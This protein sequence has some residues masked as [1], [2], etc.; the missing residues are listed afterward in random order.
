MPELPEVETVRRGLA[1]HLVG[2]RLQGARVRE[3]RLRWPVPD[4][5]DARLRGQPILDL[6]RRGKYLL[7]QL[8]DGHLIL[9]LGMS[10]SLRLTRSDSPPGPHDHLDLLLTD[11]QAL[12]FRDPRRFG[13]VLWSVAPLQHPLL[14]RLG[15]EPLQDGFSGDWLYAA[16]RQ[17]RVPIKTLLMDAHLI[18]GVGNI[19]ANEALFRAGIHP[20]CPAGRLGRARCGRLAEA[21]KTTLAA[22]IRAG[23]S[24]L[25]DFVDGHGNPGYFQQSYF[26]YGRAGEPCRQC[27]R[28]I[29]SIRQA[30]RATYYCVAC[31]HR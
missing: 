30:G 18:V 3:G 17:R 6:A 25:R 12:R 5:L 8:G 13:A 20:L 15:V 31:Q 21:V 19:Y 27:G 10:G 11:G 16:T 26:V 2:Q 23:G 28:P 22:A 9:H 14:A 4:D 7:I 1:P 29:R 24:S